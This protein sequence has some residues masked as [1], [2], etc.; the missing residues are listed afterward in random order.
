[1]KIQTNSSFITVDAW[2]HIVTNVVLR[3]NMF[4]IELDF[5]IVYIQSR[6]RLSFHYDLRRAGLPAEFKHITK[7]RKRK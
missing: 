5:R 3:L 2:I 1:M 6:V 7:R 4:F